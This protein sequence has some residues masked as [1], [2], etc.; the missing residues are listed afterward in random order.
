MK[1]GVKS[2]VFTHI[3]QQIVR[4]LLVSG[5]LWYPTWTTEV[6]LMYR[7]W[8]DP[9]ANFYG[10][11]GLVWLLGRLPADVD[12]VA[13]RRHH[14]AWGVGFE[15]SIDLML[16]FSIKGVSHQLF[17]AL[18]TMGVI[19]ETELT[20]KDKQSIE[21]SLTGTWTADTSAER[22]ITQ[23][24]QWPLHTLLQHVSKPVRSFHTPLPL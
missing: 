1:A 2:A 20:E 3:L 18:Q 15:I 14:L 13:W 19:W 9:L 10:V 21:P 6:I 22:D 17:E 16:Q 23:T 7:C 11:E 8:H 12:E 24:S 4:R 5:S